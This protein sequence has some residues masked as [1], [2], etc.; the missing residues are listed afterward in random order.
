MVD[1]RQI[2]VAAVGDLHYDATRGTSFRDMFSQVNKSADVLAI[3]GDITTHGKPE[4]MLAFVKELA[5]VEIPIVVVLGNHDYEAGKADELTAILKDRG[6]YVLDGDYA[7]I[8][9]IGFAGAK[10]FAGGFGRGA[11]APFGELLIKEFVQ[12]ALDEA[13]K[14]ENALRSVHADIKVVLLHYAP[15]IETVIG[16]PEVIWPFLGSSRLLQPI[17]TIGADVVFHGHAHHG[18]FQAKTPAGIPVYNVALPILAERGEDFFV[19]TAPAPD[20]RR[21]REPLQR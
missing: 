8:Q 17:D 14:L 12:A 19:W 2:R 6:V 16:E 21:T 4:Q 10:G 11:L 20:R 18:S 15:L 13:L 5:G 7:V 1:A 9:G 3:A